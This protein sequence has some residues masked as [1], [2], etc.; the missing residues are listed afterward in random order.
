LDV[1]VLVVCLQNHNKP[2]SKLAQKRV[3]PPSFF[4]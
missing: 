1:K 3:L 4:V 2:L